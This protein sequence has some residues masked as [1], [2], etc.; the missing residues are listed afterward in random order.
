METYKKNI[1][2]VGHGF[3]GKAVY[4]AIKEH[5]Q[6]YIVDPKYSD[7]KIEDFPDVDGFIVCVGTPSLSDGSCDV[8][9]VKAVVSEIKADVPILIKSTVTPDNLGSLVNEFPDKVICYSPEFLRATTA[10]EDFA[11]QQYVVLGGDD[12]DGF[13]EQTLSVAL[14]KCK[15]FF[16]CTIT[17][18]STVKY[19]ANSFLATKVSFFNQIYDLC[20][21]SGADYDTVRQILTHDQRI[22]SSHTLVPGLDGDRGFGGH[23]FPKDTKALLHYA[24]ALG[25]KLDTLVSAVEYNKTVRK[26]LDL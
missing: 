24:D 11:N 8:S 7:N 6:C 9:Q 20:Q 2:V 21:A 23:C 4:N 5:H 17:E 12:A 19:A 16:R 18:A 26:T 15:I 14:P 22:G 25:V 1:V 13:W 3:V 10:D